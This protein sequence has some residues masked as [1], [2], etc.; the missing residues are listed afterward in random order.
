MLFFHT[1][2][3][4]ERLTDRQSS[5]DS[6]SAP[7]QEYMNKNIINLKI[8]K[9]WTLYVFHDTLNFSTSIKHIMEYSK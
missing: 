6:A 5:I 2:I 9:I 4:T 3:Q 8:S 7:E 1:D